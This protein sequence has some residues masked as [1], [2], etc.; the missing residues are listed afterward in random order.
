MATTTN[1]SNHYRRNTATLS[2]SIPQDFND[3]SAGFGSAGSLNSSSRYG[4]QRNP[5]L[6]ELQGKRMKRQR[7]ILYGLLI[8]TMLAYVTIIYIMFT[9]NPLQMK[10]AP[11]THN[12]ECRLLSASAPVSSSFSGR[13]RGFVGELHYRNFT[14]DPVRIIDPGQSTGGRLRTDCDIPCV[15]LN[16]APADGKRI[17]AVYGKDILRTMESAQY[18]A[19]TDVNVAHSRG[20]KYVM[21]PRLSSDVP[22]GYFSWAEYA[23]G[24][25]VAAD[26]KFRDDFDA[27]AVISNCAP[28]SFRMDAVAKLEE[29]G[30]RVDKYGACFKRPLAGSKQDALRQYRFTLAFENSLEEDY[31]TE[32]YWQALEVGSVPVVIGAPNI[33]D[34][35]PSSM[36]IIH[37]PSLDEVPAAAD[38]IKS[39]MQN[40]Q[41][42]DKMLDWKRTGPSEKFLALID[43][44]VVHSACRLCVKV[45]SESYQTTLD[46]H[47][48]LRGNH[49]DMGKCDCSSDNGSGIMKRIFI[50]ERG[51]FEFREMTL[52]A[53][54]FRGLD[55]DEF[56]YQILQFFKSIPGYKAVWSGHR[57]DFF[58]SSTNLKLHRVYPAFISQRQALYGD[59]AIDTSD[60]I[61][62]LLET[63]CPQL[64]VIF[65]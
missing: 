14:L 10:V 21:T 64:E 31:V 53:P 51:R 22:V 59:E 58:S 65:V 63:P 38:K 27:I 4:K 60:E 42:Y 11:L 23:I 35:E 46:Q 57:K 43:M 16:D 44:A 25:T 36:S 20:Y 40:P 32:K 48:A 29:L 6:H 33:H 28:N 8:L 24:S 37:I 39:L 49:F 18:Y 30:V 19:D 5:K 50:R 2:I 54:S 45:G 56:H 12:G 7:M 55:L 13:S 1:L 52:L 62:K 34:F 47:L 26:R 15:Y 61:M 9:L 41:E 3:I 17:D